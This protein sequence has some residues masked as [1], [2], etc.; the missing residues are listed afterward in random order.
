[1]KELIVEC[2]LFGALKQSEKGKQKLTLPENTTYRQLLTNYFHFS[3]QHLRY[4][5]VLENEQQIKNLDTPVSQ[6]AKIK[7]LLPLGGG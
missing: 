5:V 7:I 6:S 4:L 3:S 2:E 1:M